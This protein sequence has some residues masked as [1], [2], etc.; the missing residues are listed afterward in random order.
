MAEDR[1]EQRRHVFRLISGILQGIAL[2]RRSVDER[3]V[4][5]FIRGV[6]IHQQFQRL[7]HNLFRARAGTVDLIDADDEG[8]IQCQRFLRDKTSLRHRSFKCVYH[9]DDSVYHLQDTLHLSAE[10]GVAGRVDD[11]DLCPVVGNSCVLG[12]DRNAALTL[13]VSRVHDTLGHLLIIAEHAALM[14]Q[15][16]HKRCLAVVNV[17]NDGNISD[18][19]SSHVL[20]L[21]FQMRLKTDLHAAIQAEKWGAESLQN[22]NGWIPHIPAILHQTLTGRQLICAGVTGHTQ[23][24]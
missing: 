19:F 12:Q 2:L 10:I 24:Y 14:E 7:I 11:V 13:E 8:K 5:L 6:Q 9:Q 23:C 1:L 22:R 20:S 3:T 16:I 4:K 21:Y 18:I 17:C 15:A